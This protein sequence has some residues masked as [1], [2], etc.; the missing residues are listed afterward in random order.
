MSDASSPEAN[1]SV[2]ANFQRD[3]KCTLIYHCPLRAW[4]CC[5]FPTPMLASSLVTRQDAHWIQRR[6]PLHARGTPALCFEEVAW[7]VSALELLPRQWGRWPSPAWPRLVGRWARRGAGTG[8]G[9][10]VPARALGGWGKS[11][12]NSCSAE[13][14]VSIAGIA[15]QHA[16]VWFFSLMQLRKTAYETR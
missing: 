2:T 15:I 14:S 6:D 8:H 12:W 10:E 1:G 13:V 5:P 9:A 16:Q 3:N 11:G 7:A 4:S